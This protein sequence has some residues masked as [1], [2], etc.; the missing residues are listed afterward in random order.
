LSDDEDIDPKEYRKIL[1]NQNA[2]MFKLQNYKDT[3]KLAEMKGSLH[4]LVA[5]KI[6]TKTLFFYK[7]DD[8]EK[9]E[10]SLQDKENTKNYNC[11]KERLENI[12]VF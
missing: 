8:L 10:V 9:Y 4:L 1:K 12:N 5:P 2:S 3:K 7:E 11:D 6:N